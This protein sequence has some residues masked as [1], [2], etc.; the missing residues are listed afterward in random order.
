[1]NN[2]K[3]THIMHATDENFHENSETCIDPNLTTTDKLFLVPDKTKAK[4]AEEDIS[5]NGHRNRLRTRFLKSPESLPDYELLEL[6]LFMAKPRVDVKPLAKQLL[7][8]FKT[9][10]ALTGADILTLKNLKNVGE[11]TI[12]AIK[13]IPEILR[14]LLC[15]H[16]RSEPLLN[17]ADS[18]I[19]YCYAT[20][21]FLE[22]E[23][24]R[25][26]YINRKNFFICDDIHNEGTLDRTCMYPREIIKRAFSL[27]AGGILIIHNHPSGDCTPSQ[28]DILATKQLKD[29]LHQVEINLLDHI[30][31][32]KLGF[33]S[34]KQ[35]GYLD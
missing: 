34:F 4:S 16:I 30:V 25:I 1:M 32:A 29:A 33:F 21:A 20:M 23:Q 28:G 3:H 31:I 7:K 8:H 12:V 35:H 17:S 2:E 10:A 11:T 13:M 9:F 22:I 14:R 24:F 19:A 6:F 18:V 27:N 5:N 26:L 15:D